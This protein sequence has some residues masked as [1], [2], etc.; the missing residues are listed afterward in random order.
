MKKIAVALVHGIGNTPA[1]FADAMIAELKQRFESA[2]PGVVADDALAFAPVYWG[3]ILQTPEN[4]L[5]N[6]LKKGTDMDFIAL[7]RFMVSFAAD[8]L[9]YQPLPYERSKYE[10][11]H[12]VFAESLKRLAALAGPTAPL[13]VVSHSLGTIVTS[14]YFYDLSRPKLIPA[15]VKAAMT[16]PRAT[17]LERGRTFTALYTLGSPIA[18]WSLRYADFGK[19]IQVPSAPVKPDLAK[20]GGWFNFYD[21]DDV[22]GYPLKTL[23]PAYKAAVK[24]DRPLNSGGILTSWNPVSHI[25]Y[26][27]D[28]DVTKPIAARLTAL[29]QF[30]NP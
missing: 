18:L 17:A 5:W 11:V 6:R 4:E 14:N 22:I 7:R 23:N 27:T 16:A 20:H 1:D 26:W 29:S 10:E 28:N 2:N 8:A 3:P 13:V 24:E 15:P 25:S 9:A 12:T 21:P 19:P 30:L